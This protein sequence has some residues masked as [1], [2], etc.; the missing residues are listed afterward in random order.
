MSEVI[1]AELR[2][3]GSRHACTLQ[4]ETILFHAAFPVDV[5]HNAK[6]FRDRLAVWAAEQL[7]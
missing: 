1:R 5:R 7:P 2:E 4:I 6:I 3:L